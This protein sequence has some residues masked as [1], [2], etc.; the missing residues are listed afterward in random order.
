M[1]DKIKISIPHSVYEVL[2]KDCSDFKILHNDNTNNNNLFLNLLI[3]NYYEEFSKSDQKLN[4]DLLKAIN[5]I[6][7]K[8]KTEVLKN[9]IKA[10][11]TN[12][13]IDT[14]KEKTKVIAFKPTKM[15]NKNIIYIN[16][17]LINDE[18]ISSFY[19]R[20][21]I[22]Y[23]K[24]I[25]NEREKIIFKDNYNL[26]IKAIND[27]VKVCLTLKSKQLYKDVS[28]YDIKTPKDEFY[29]YILISSKNNPITLRLSNISNVILLPDKRIFD[30]KI[31]N[32]FNKQIKY[33]VQYNV[34]KKEILPVKIKLTPQ[35]IKL[36]E[37]IYLYRPEYDSHEG[38][39]YT[40]LG[41]YEQI[42]HYFKRFGD[43]AIIL[44]PENLRIAMRNF[45]YFANKAYK[46]IEKPKD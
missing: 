16:N 23:T 39:I 28:V 38:D 6:P 32:I 19:R 22:S 3:T 24:K 10:F 1:E 17:Y 34:S 15:S 30:D 11:N 33:G 4:K 31:I 29:N 27:D 5:Q 25:K 8:N 2:I 20:L 46:L 36:Y 45:Y 26:L 41:P 40:F 7:E 18:S 37:K 12:N 43:D 44:E 13:I 9:I 42:L 21:L 35:G 14:P